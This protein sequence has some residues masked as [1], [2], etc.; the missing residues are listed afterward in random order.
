MAFMGYPR[1]VRSE[2]YLYVWLSFLNDYFL[3]FILLESYIYIYIYVL[4]RTIVLSYLGLGLIL[5]LDKFE[6]NWSELNYSGFA[7]LKNE[8]K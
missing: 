8:N 5:Y 3:N 2:I 7:G 4:L 6:L 1:I